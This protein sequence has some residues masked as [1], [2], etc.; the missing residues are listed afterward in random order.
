MPRNMLW[1]EQTGRVM[2]TDFERAEVV[3]LRTVLGTAVTNDT[4]LCSDQTTFKL[5]MNK[6]FWPTTRRRLFELSVPS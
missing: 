3:K 6:Q 2:G 5:H 1:N 4:L